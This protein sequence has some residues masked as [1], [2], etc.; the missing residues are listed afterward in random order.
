MGQQSQ[1]KSAAAAPLDDHSVYHVVVVPRHATKTALAQVTPANATQGGAFLKH[2]VC[3]GAKTK[4]ACEAKPLKALAM[5]SA[6]FFMQVA[7]VAVAS[8][9]AYDQVR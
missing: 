1:V 6:S 9:A 2:E 5:N 7:T 8:K 4:T 3:L